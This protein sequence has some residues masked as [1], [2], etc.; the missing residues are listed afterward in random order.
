[1]FANSSPKK[2]AFLILVFIYLVYLIKSALGINLLEKY[3]VPQF[4]KYPLMVADCAVDLKINFCKKA[5]R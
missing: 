4:I 5:F 1:M 3:A 2:K